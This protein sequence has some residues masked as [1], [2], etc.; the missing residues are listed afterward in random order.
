MKDI[1]QANFLLIHK[2]TYFR[3][4][5]LPQLMEYHEHETQQT[6]TMHLWRAK[7]KNQNK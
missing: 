4:Y 7:K 3:Y 2:S 1:I 6:K 5:Y